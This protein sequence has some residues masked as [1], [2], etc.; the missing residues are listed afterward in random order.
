M[1]LDVGEIRPPQM[2]KTEL[3]GKFPCDA[4]SAE[5][6]R[7]CR[8]P[9]QLA[10]RQ[11]VC[12]CPVATTHLVAAASLPVNF[13]SCISLMVFPKTPLGDCDEER[14]GVSGFSSASFHR[15]L[16]HRA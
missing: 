7:I 16:V 11:R 14:L 3:P 4:V 1:A 6:C 2:K 9:V 8:G 12:C 13:E 5:S 15:S 10:S